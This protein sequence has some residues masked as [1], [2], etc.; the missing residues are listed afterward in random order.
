[1]SVCEVL[2]KENPKLPTKTKMCYAVGCLLVHPTEHMQPPSFYMPPCMVITCHMHVHV[3]V[4]MCR[5]GL[6][7]WRCCWPDKHGP[8]MYMYKCLGLVIV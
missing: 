8:C 7:L 2:V 1:M 3:Q 4:H 5:Y 6:L